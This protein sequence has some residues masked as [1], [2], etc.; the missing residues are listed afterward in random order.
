[1]SQFKV[2]GVVDRTFTKTKSTRMGDKIINY[3]TVDGKEFSTGFKKVFSE[4]EMV[5]IVVEFKYGEH[6]YVP[7]AVPGSQPDMGSAPPPQ[8]SKPA[9][10]GGGGG[11]PAS[12]FPVQPTDGQ[13]SIIRQ[14][15]M[16]R[17]VEILDSWQA[18]G[19]IQFGNDQDAYLKK[20]LEVAMT[21]T[22]FNSGQD[23]MKMQATMAAQQGVMNG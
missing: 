10:G 1:M 5:N 7:N 11:R 12:K 9:W 21:V 22:D 6:Q 19:I 23:I 2:N 15:S 20:L 3:A 4:G 8:A 14:N 17:A 13:M 18:H 16:N